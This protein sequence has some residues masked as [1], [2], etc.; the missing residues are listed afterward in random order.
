MRTAR[1]GEEMLDGARVVPQHAA[2]P[3]PEPAVLGDDDTACLEG[4]GR[5][6]DRLLAA[7]DAEVRVAR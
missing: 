4:F 3:D 6:L 2:F 1:S 5:L 7:R